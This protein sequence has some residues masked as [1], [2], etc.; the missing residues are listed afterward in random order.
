MRTHEAVMD[1]YCFGYPDERVG[2]EVNKLAYKLYV[3][4]YLKHACLFQYNRFAFGLNLNRM[5]KM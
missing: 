3:Y 4:I 2:E 5:L 1:A